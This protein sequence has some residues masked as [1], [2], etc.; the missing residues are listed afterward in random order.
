VAG[1]AGA[2]YGSRVNCPGRASAEDRQEGG[3]QGRPE[4]GAPKLVGALVLARWRDPVRRFAFHDAVL[5]PTSCAA[6]PRAKRSSI[7]R[8]PG[9][10][11]WKG[12]GRR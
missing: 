4:R 2:R 7:G 8:I 9:Y 6:G 10:R 1:G 3:D 12:A 5:S 11:L